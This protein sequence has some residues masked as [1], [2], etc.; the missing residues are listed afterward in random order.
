MTTGEIPMTANTTIALEETED[1]RRRRAGALPGGKLVAAGVGALG[2]LLLGG[3]VFGAWS[4]S[5]SMASQAHD[6]AVVDAVLADANGTTFATAVSDLLPGDY[7]HR[8]V[9]L[10]NTGSVDQ[11][12]TGTVTGTGALAPALTVEVDSCST[13]WLADGSCSGVT[14]ALQG[15]TATD[16]GTTMPFPSVAPDDTHYVRFRFMLAPD[17]DQATYQGTAASEQISIS[18]GPTTPGGRDRTAD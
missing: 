8:Y 17:A 13:A 18:G 16:P 15:P 11:T 7:L 5:G 4:P 1:R 2:L 6:A 12:F 9:D 3:G 10:I 14:T